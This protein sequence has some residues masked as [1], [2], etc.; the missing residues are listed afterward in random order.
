VTAP[1]RIFAGGALVAAIF[2]LIGANAAAADPIS[3]AAYRG[4]LDSARTQVERARATSGAE[5]ATA[6]AA[7]A[8]TVR[9][10]TE[11]RAGDA[12]FNALPHEPLL[13]L[14]RSGD[15]TSLDRAAGMLQQTI[16]V[17]DT[18]NARG[19]D[20]ASARAMLQAVLGSSDFRAQP[21]WRDAILELIRDLLGALFPNLTAPEFT[22]YQIAVALTGVI[23]VLLVIVANNARRGI[24]AKLTREAAIASSAAAYR[25]RAA[26]HLRA[27]DD[28]VR[29]GRLRQALRELFLG[30]LAGLEE[31]GGLSLDPA[32]TD[33]EILAR[34]AG[35][36]RAG[37]LSSLVALYEPAWYGVREPSSS[38][39]E[40]AAELAR[41]IGA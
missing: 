17:L 35:S 5:R 26:D 2:L 39:V 10:I 23:T 4:A 27:A 24:R 40:R 29:G 14:L 12:I 9:G 15:D 7:A 30:A 32:L 11:V 31:R 18:A 16:A 36:P 19:I 22:R 37:D 1:S 20:P 38:E 34:A 28:A 33:R 6:I 21:D 3:L 13:S 41:R 25:P 8:A